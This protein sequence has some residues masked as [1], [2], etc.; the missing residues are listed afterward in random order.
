[1]TYE[2]INFTGPGAPYTLLVGGD[3]RM[4]RRSYLVEL[5]EAHRNPP[6][7]DGRKVAEPAVHQQ[8]EIPREKMI[9]KCGHSIGLSNWRRRIHTCWRCREDARKA[10]RIA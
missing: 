8:S 1:M 6:A 4:C 5:G 7:R 9:C 10:R 2:S 3:A